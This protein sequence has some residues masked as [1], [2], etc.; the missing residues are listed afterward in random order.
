MVRLPWSPHKRTPSGTKRLREMCVL[1]RPRRAAAGIPPSLVQLFV[2]FPLATNLG[3]AGLR[4]GALTPAFVLL[5]NSVGWSWP[6]YWWFVMAGEALLLSRALAGHVRGWERG[7][8]R[9]GWKFCEVRME[10]T[11]VGLIWSRGWL[12]YTFRSSS[13]YMRKG[14]STAALPLLLPSTLPHLTAAV[15]PGTDS[16]M[17][18]LCLWWPCCVCC[19]DM[20]SDEEG[21]LAREGYA[22]VP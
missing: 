14:R 12:E 18:I 6:A 13:G 20:R 9:N 11:H 16:A 5:F 17:Q 22:S 1:P 10:G 15:T 7:D 4:L 19:A 2:V 21:S 3:V 8:M